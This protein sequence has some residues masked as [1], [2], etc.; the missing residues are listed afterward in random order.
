MASAA[1]SSREEGAWRPGKRHRAQG[2]VARPPAAARR[3]P[4]E[5]H[6]RLLLAREQE[7]ER[8]RVEE[9]GAGRGHVLT[10]HEE[11]LMWL[12]SRV[13]FRST[14]HSYICCVQNDGGT[15]RR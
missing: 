3:P 8:R 13:E 15:L 10:I 12:H 1:L 4:F 2:V 5:E 11:L 9:V 14:L 7:R 6:K